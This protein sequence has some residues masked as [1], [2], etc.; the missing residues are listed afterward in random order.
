MMKLIKAIEAI[1]NN[2]NI[3]DQDLN[4]HKISSHN[5]YK[6]C[7]SLGVDNVK[8]KLEELAQQ[9]KKILIRITI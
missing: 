5:C 6:F 7:K 8:T 1:N 3:S 2:P 4:N 9:K